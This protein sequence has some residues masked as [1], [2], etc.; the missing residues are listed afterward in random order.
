MHKRIF[1]DAQPAKNRDTY[2]N[3]VGELID[4]MIGDLDY[5]QC[6]SAK[7]SSQSF[8][9]NNATYD[10][11]LVSKNVDTVTTREGWFNVVLRAEVT[12]SPG[13]WIYISFYSWANNYDYLNVTFGNAP[14]EGSN[15]HLCTQ[16]NGSSPTSNKAYY[17]LQQSLT[18]PH[19]VDLSI[20]KRHILFAPM[21]S[22]CQF[23]WLAEYVRTGPFNLPGSDVIP[24]ISSANIGQFYSHN[25]P[26]V[27]VGGVQAEK[28]LEAK[29]G[30]RNW[31]NSQSSFAT[32]YLQDS[33]Y[34]TFLYKPT[35]GY[36]ETILGPM[37]PDIPLYAIGTKNWS[38]DPANNLPSNLP[39]AEVNIAGRRFIVLTGGFSTTTSNPYYLEIK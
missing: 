29:I 1:F 17:H 13:K 7:D 10:W 33:V 20:S 3:Y 25:F 24:F 37:H 31:A 8:E 14:V 15:S 22:N 36:S 11:E 21:V 32:A 9:V 26:H 27:L 4:A 39:G 19:Y 30:F 12:D 23:F 2:V 34:K 5:T 18:T 28:S 6:V 35:F 16:Q 38:G